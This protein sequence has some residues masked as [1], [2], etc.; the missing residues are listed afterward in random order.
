MMSVLA[1]KHGRTG[2]RVSCTKN[3]HELWLIIN[4][5]ISVK[6][7]NVWRNRIAHNDIGE[8]SSELFDVLECFVVRVLTEIEN[9]NE[10]LNLCEKITELEDRVAIQSAT[11]N[12]LPQLHKK[13][14]NCSCDKDFA[15]LVARIQ[16]LTL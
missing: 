11:P 16:D 4:N 13:Q 3:C 14:D 8:I 15:S 2:K 12:C 10:T 9:F 5:L 6:R 1:I 7:V